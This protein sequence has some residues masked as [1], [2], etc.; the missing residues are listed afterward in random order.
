MSASVPGF[1]V[2]LY[3]ALTARLLLGGAP[4]GLAILNG[5]VS[6]ALGLGLQQWGAGLGLFLIGHSLSVLAARYDPDFVDIIVR[7]LKHKAYLAC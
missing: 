6:A 1:E 3:Q 4:R 2:P 5:T 7:H